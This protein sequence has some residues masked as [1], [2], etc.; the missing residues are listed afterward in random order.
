MVGTKEI[1]N[2]PDARYYQL[3]ENPYIPEKIPLSKANDISLR[4]NLSFDQNIIECAHLIRFIDEQISANGWA[5]YP[6]YSVKK[7]YPRFNELINTLEDKFKCSIRYN[8]RIF[9]SS[10]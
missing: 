1:V 9:T 7:K 2:S 4:Y 6:L 5:C 3:L 8:F 10:G